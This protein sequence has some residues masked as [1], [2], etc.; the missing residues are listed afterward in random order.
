MREVLEV[1]RTGSSLPLDA[2]YHFSVQE[3]EH[4]SLSKNFSIHICSLLVYNVAIIF[5]IT[6]C[7]SWL[8][9]I[10]CHVSDF[11]CLIYIR[12]LK[13]KHTVRGISVVKVKCFKF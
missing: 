10:L 7:F 11:V 4:C 12:S 2:E 5:R 13:G 6:T 8:T 3:L 9:I 1:V